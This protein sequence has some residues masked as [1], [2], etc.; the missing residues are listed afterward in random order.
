[1]KIEERI[2]FNEIKSRNRQVFE[3]LFR[4]YYPFLTKF[5]EGFV[6]DRQ[7]AEDI[8]Q[9]LFLHFW[10]NVSHIEIESSIRSYL[11]QSVR[12]RCLNYLR[13]LHVQDKHRLLYI[14]AGLNSE[15]PLIWQE[16]DLIR[17]IQEAI[18]SL[19]VQMRELFVMKYLQGMKTKEIAGMKGISENTIKTQLQRAKEKLR[20]KLSETTSFYF[21]L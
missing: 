3:G 11:Y 8:V 14:E 20:R 16:T 1:M 2:L 5:A 21:F 18:D 19:P 10:E 12:N 4:E 13:D 15:D 6:F 9:N 7:V 17:Q